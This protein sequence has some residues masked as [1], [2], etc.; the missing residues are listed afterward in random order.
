MRIRLGTDR[1][2]L[3]RPQKTSAE[4]DGCHDLRVCV[5]WETGGDRIG[6]TRCSSYAHRTQSDGVDSAA[7][8][9]GGTRQPQTASSR[10]AIGRSS[11]TS[12]VETEKRGKRV[13][14]VRGDRLAQGQ[15]PDRGFVL[16]TP[17]SAVARHRPPSIWNDD[18]DE[19]QNEVRQSALIATL[20]GLRVS[21]FHRNGG[22]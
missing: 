5:A 10:R 4:L 1:Q 2:G 20:L 16:L 19:P 3:P 14:R 11:Q 13:V 6:D 22:L 18:S 17:W 8:E 12:W 21:L 7:C 15:E 9:R